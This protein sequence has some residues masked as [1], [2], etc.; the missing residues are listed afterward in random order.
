LCLASHHICC[1]WTTSGYLA[2]NY[3]KHQ[4]GST[5]NYIPWSINLSVIKNFIFQYEVAVVVGV[6]RKIRCKRLRW[7]RSSVLAFGTLVHG[8]A[9]GRSRRIFRAKKSSACLP[10]EGK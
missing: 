10:S 8:F 1:R 9:S 7:S 5:F 2:C 6:T 3:N 4:L